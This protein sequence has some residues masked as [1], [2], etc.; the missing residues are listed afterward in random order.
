M[1][2]GFFLAFEEFAGVSLAIFH[3][4]FVTHIG[5]LVENTLSFV[6]D[7]VLI[8]GIEHHP[9]PFLIVGEGHAIVDVE[10]VAEFF[11]ID[12][13][14]DEV[15]GPAEFFE[16]GDEGAYLMPI[17]LLGIILISVGDDCHS[18]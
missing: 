2:W 16:L 9:G 17:V 4:I 1:S 14:S 13:G 5:S 11:Y 18:H 7:I 3:F 15:E 12:V 10:S 6:H 8:E